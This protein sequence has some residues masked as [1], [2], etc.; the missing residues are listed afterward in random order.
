MEIL[1]SSSL[2]L[3]IA[4][5]Y[6][7]SAVTPGPNFVLTLHNSIRYGRFAG[8]VTAVGLATGVAVHLFYTNVGFAILIKNSPLVFSVIKYLGAGYLLYLAY[9][10]FSEVDQSLHIDKDADVA[11]K[12][13][14]TWNLFKQS[15]L[16]SALNP[17][18]TLFF[19]SIF[20]TF[21][22]QEIGM[23]ALMLISVILVLLEFSWFT[24]V[25]FV[26]TQKFFLQ[27]YYQYQKF[28]NILFGIILV[29]LAI[30]V[31]VS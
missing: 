22:P 3:N 2:L 16:T 5:L 13:F 24:L 30:R 11:N 31:L 27:K 12:N 23:F 19:L 6:L 14:I 28:V 8:V 21:V 18:L 1:F 9:K 25:G 17:K 10:I 26:F 20:T 7:L 29:V 15:F 4:V